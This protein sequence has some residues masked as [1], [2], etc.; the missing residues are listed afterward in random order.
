MHRMTYEMQ[1]PSA[2]PAG[3]PVGLVGPGGRTQKLS[4]AKCQK[5]SDFFN[6]IQEF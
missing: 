2:P 5:T 3:K 6:G 4:S 1:L